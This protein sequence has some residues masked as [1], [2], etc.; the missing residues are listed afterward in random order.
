VYKADADYMLGGRPVEHGEYPWMVRIYLNREHLCGGTLLGS[1][2]VI[3]AA[4][5]VVDEPIK[6][7]Y[8]VAVGS[9]RLPPVFDKESGR[10]VIC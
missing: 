4:H 1:R 5:C 8:R 10:H 3:T 6:A 2:T 7:R 9:T